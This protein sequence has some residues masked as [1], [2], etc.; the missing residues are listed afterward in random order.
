M[1]QDG[2]DTHMQS[3]FERQGP[4]QT[5]VAKLKFMQKVSHKGT[6]KQKDRS[7]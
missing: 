4:R 2:K 1:T 7:T 3:L 5:Q 6:K